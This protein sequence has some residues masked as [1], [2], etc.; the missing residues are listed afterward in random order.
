MLPKLNP[1]PRNLVV[2]K[3]SYGMWGKDE[4]SEHSTSDVYDPEKHV[5]VSHKE[6][7]PDVESIVHLDKHG[8]P[9]VP[10]PSRFK[11]DPLVR[12]GLFTAAC[13][14][15]LTLRVELACV[16]QVG[17]PDTGQFHGLP[18]SFQR[19]CG[20]SKSGPIKRRH[21]CFRHESRL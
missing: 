19:C 6:Y 15:S 7:L 16:A 9:L 12:I 10:Q 21:A 8:L 3:K 13:Q 5:D 1:G 20:E 18:G 11:D 17:H 2:H 4:M 14:P